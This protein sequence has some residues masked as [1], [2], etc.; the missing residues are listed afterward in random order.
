MT[1]GRDIAERHA[2]RVLVW[3]HLA[4]CR[5][6]GHD[7]LCPEHVALLLAALDAEETALLAGRLVRRLCPEEDWPLGT[8][9]LDRLGRH[10]RG[11]SCHLCWGVPAP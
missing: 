10:R 3:Q 11:C 9:D 1:A 8:P 6:E 4:S 2:A 7:V 5:L